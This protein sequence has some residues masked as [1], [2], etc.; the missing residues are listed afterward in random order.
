VAREASVK[1]KAPIPGDRRP[2]MTELMAVTIGWGLLVVALV[3]LGYLI[4]RH[5]R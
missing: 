5:N 3:V 4:A 1:P 2:T